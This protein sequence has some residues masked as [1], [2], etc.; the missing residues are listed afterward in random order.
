MF[1]FLTLFFLSFLTLGHLERPRILDPNDYIYPLEGVAGLYSASFGELRPNH[2]HSGADIKTDG[3]IGKRVVAV[4]DGYV[5]RIAVS[6]YGYGLAIYVAHPN[7]TT[8]V[9][10]HL[11]R[12]NDEIHAWVESEIYRTKKNSVSL[13]PTAD[14]FPVKQGDLIAYSG[15]SGSSSGPHL[16]FEIRESASQKTLNVMAQGVV[17]SR[18]T[19]A[20]LI[21]RI[22][23]MEVDSVG[24]VAYTS[25]MRT[26]QA[27]STTTDEYELEVDNNEIVVGRK[28]YFIVEASDRKDD[29]T[30]RFGLYSLRS[31]LDEKPYFEY[32]MD[33]FTFPS[34]RYCNAVSYYPIKLSSV[35]EVIRV[36]QLGNG[37][38]QF[39][40]TMVDR[41]LVR[42]AA[43]SVR[44]VRLEAEDDMGNVSGLSFKIKGGH[45]PFK[46]EI[47][48]T[49]K[50]VYANKRFFHKEEGASVAIDSYTLYESIPFEYNVTPLSEQRKQSLVSTTCKVEIV[51]P[52]YKVLDRTIPLHKGM[53]VDIEAEIEPRLQ[54][55]ALIAL[56]GKTGKI[57]NLGGSYNNGRVGVD[58]RSA[59]EFVVAIDTVRPRVVP[60]F[61]VGANL[62]SRKSISFTISDNFSGVAGYTGYINGEWVALDYHGGRVTHYF[63][64]KPTGGEHTMR[65]VVSDGRNNTTSVERRF[66]R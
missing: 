6:P 21:F 17:K 48:T 12:F 43:D 51:T 15:N 5:A 54:S 61:E 63:R 11:S 7:G 45:E 33:G 42:C 58:T 53:R 36:A 2:F 50:I 40:P 24:G 18:D 13:F 23:Y 44:R 29:V 8:S 55:K 46:A 64:D 28:G 14:Q 27:K 19:R 38:A 20:P 56:V 57:F 62:T 26:F 59:G 39:Y 1:Q 25:K 65:V 34:T 3:V 41:G 66:R 60:N 49:Q 47:D 10:A 37:S 30:N 52:I 9:Y 31:Y 16:H 32:R 4:A 22:H 35:N